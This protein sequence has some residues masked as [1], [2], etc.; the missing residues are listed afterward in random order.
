[1]TDKNKFLLIAI[2]LALI[3]VGIL[4]WYSQPIREDVPA[5]NP[6]DQIKSQLENRSFYTTLPITPSA[7]Q[8]GK[9]NPFK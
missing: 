2:G 7:G 8:T 4:F 6:V 3:L 1:M 5:V 9:D